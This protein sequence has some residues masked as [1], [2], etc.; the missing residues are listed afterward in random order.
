MEISAAESELIMDFP[1][2]IKENDSEALAG[3]VA[4]H[5]RESGAN[6]QDEVALVKVK[7]KRAKVTFESEAAI[8]KGKQQKAVKRKRSKAEIVITKEQAE[9]ALG[10]IE[11]EEHKPKKKKK[12]A[13]GPIVT[14]MFVMTPALERMANE[15]ATNLIDDR[16]E[17]KAQ[18]IQEWDEKMKALGLEN[19]DEYFKMKSAKVKAIAGVAAE[20]DLEED[21]MIVVEEEAAIGQE[22]VEE[23]VPQMGL[24]I[25]EEEVQG[26]P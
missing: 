20:D 4:V 14:P 25:A 16:K 12:Q 2:I 6:S 18:Y 1:S 10:E 8:G 21:M 13:Y 15:R 3:L 22:V 24:E 23:E 19:C 17:K 26:T 5:D 7:G 11:E 9:K